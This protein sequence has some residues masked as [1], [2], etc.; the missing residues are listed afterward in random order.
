[1]PEEIRAFHGDL[2]EFV[3][4]G[5]FNARNAFAIKRDT[6]K[7][8]Q[9]G[10][11]VGGPIMKD[12][13]FFFA[14]YQG[15]RIRQDP[16]DSITFVPTPAMLAGDWTAVTSPACNGGRQI[17][18]K[19]PF[20]NNR[21]NPAQFAR[22][23]VV[24]AGKLPTTTD[25]C[26]KVV[27]GDTTLQNG[28]MAIGRIDYQRSASHSVFG[29]YLVEGELIPPSYDL[30]HSILTFINSSVGTDGL[31]QA[32][33]LGDTY[34]FGANVVNS[35][36][37]SANRMAG[38]K[39]RPGGLAQLDAGLVD[40]GVKMFSYD[41][42]V[43][44]FN[45]TGGTSM[46]VQDGPS[47]LATFAASDDIN[48]LRGNHQLAAGASAASWWVISNSN[49]WSPGRMAFD[50]SVTGLGMGDFFVGTSSQFIMGTRTDQSKRSEYIGVY[51]ADTWKVNQKLTLNYGLRWEP[52]FPM[53]NLDGSSVHFDVDAFRKGIKTTRFTN[54]PAGLFFDGDPGFPSGQGMHNK[55]WN[56]SPRL[57]LAWNV[58]G[59][60]RTSVR[61]S[62]G[63]FYD[64]PSTRDMAGLPSLPPF[65][66]RYTLTSVSLENPWANQPG[67]DP[68]P[69]PYGRHVSSDTAWPLYGLGVA[70]DYDSSN[71]QV[72]QWNLS[73]QRQIGADLLVSAT[74]LGN[75]T[76]HFWATQPFNPAVY[77]PGGPC[78]LNGVAYNPCSTTANTDQRR[79]LVLENPAVGQY[80]GGVLR[81]DTGGTS[82]YNGMLLSVQRRA[83]RGVTVSGN[84]TWS[85]CITDAQS[86][87]GVISA[88]AGYTNPDNRRFDRGNC[89]IAGTDRRHL[90]NLSAVAETPRFANP[91]L[92]ALGSGWR[93]SP[94]F[95]VLSGS[96][97]T[98]TTSQDR[99]LNGVSSQRVNLLQLNPYGAKTV[100]NYLNPAAFALPALGTFGNTGVGGIAGPGSWQFDTALSR[101]FQFRETQKLEFRAEAFNI[102]NSFRMDI[103]KLTTNYNSNTFG[104]VTGALD[105]RIMQFALKYF[106]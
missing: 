100:K 54:A 86:P 31:A 51:G 41:P 47:R 22:P 40:V 103:N 17:T 94:I 106:F 55:W 102:T 105:P 9:Y 74:Y 32:F 24:F 85:H 50:G 16:S 52:F 46:S 78:T 38:G 69:R 76:A 92:R 3:R 45:I 29:R 6:I 14:G 1:L 5:M 8:N 10:G 56:F 83:A 33:T 28:Y 13:L 30:N 59:D 91:A 66:L 25:A 36:R 23:A 27:Y 77:I 20:V 95:K 79:R 87:I 60:G 90:F 12:K 68:F 63:T 70:L 81:V 96:F 89:T 18:L 62:A 72:Q 71:M 34:L 64:F 75:H 19:A 61:A 21:I 84:Y 65:N 57:G 39:T 88:T 44:Y 73:L 43:P 93:L 26:G 11:T 97:L 98:V 49:S 53:T 37:L 58:T 99:A 7:R 35:V 67:G 48:V 82:S 80:Y 42:H 4:N 104:Q 15:T 101:T 2:F